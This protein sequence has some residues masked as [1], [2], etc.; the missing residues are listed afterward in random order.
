MLFQDD[1]DVGLQFYNQAKWVDVPRRHGCA[2]VNI[3]EMF[4]IAT[5]GYFAATM[6]RV[7]NCSK[8]RYSFPFFYNAALQTP[9][10]RL[11]GAEAL[12]LPWERDHC[13]VSA[14]DYNS[15][16]TVQSIYGLNALKSL[17]RSHPAVTLKHHSDLRVEHDGSIRR[18]RKPRL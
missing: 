7:R 14:T 12:Q 17:A 1:A 13:A 8:S 15:N 4:E 2:V 6:H 16:N 9:I 3:G 5:G 10:K 11:V 18:E